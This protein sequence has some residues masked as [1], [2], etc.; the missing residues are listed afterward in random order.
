MDT[1]RIEQEL[2][3]EMESMIR[4]HLSKRSGKKRMNLDREIHEKVK[5][6][7]EK[8][9]KER[10]KRKDFLK[11]IP[12]FGAGLVLGLSALADMGETP[13]GRKIAGGEVNPCVYS[14]NTGTCN[15]GEAQWW[16]ASGDDSTFPPTCNSG[17]YIGQ[18]CNEGTCNSGL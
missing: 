7:V 12:L 16:C 4:E 2:R 5:E 10:M 14:C 18:L 8:H 3:R 11:K 15:S 6:M 9:R 13:K 1:R 17:S